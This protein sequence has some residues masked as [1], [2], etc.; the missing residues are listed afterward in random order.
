ML[1][2][3]WRHFKTFL[4]SS[5]IFFY[6]PLSA[7]FLFFFYSPFGKSAHND[8]FWNLSGM[9]LNTQHPK[10]NVMAFVYRCVCL[11]WLNQLSAGMCRDLALLWVSTRVPPTLR[12]RPDLC[13]NKVILLIPFHRRHIELWPNR[14]HT[15]SA[16]HQ[17]GNILCELDVIGMKRVHS[18]FLWMLLSMPWNFRR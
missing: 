1:Q 10:R 18:L 9:G 14:R 11:R 16:K 15:I 6:S 5:F 7:D 4:C 13:R 12:L 2:G 17:S 3:R 8:D